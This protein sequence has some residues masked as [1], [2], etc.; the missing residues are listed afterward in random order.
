MNINNVYYA[1]IYR[2]TN[3]ERKKG[4]R[5]TLI[6]KSCLSRNTIVYDKNNGEFYDLITNKTLACSYKL[7][8]LKGSEKVD[9]KSLI[10]FDNFIKQSRKNLSKREIIKM[11]KEYEKINEEAI[12]NDI[13]FE[14]LKDNNV[15]KKQKR[16]K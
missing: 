12:E 16:R 15:N 1:E 4:A 10:P 8:D 7:E 5:W 11:Y 2:L 6:F 9:L 14:D 13:L 3:I